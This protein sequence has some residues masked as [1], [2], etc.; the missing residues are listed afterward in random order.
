MNQQVVIGHQT[1]KGIN[2]DAVAVMALQSE[3][4]Y[5]LSV[6][7][8]GGGVNVE[9]DGVA[10]LAYAFNGLL[11]DGEFGVISN[12]ATS[13]FDSFT[14][15]TDDVAYTPE[16]NLIAAA[17][18]AVFPLSSQLESSQL[19][20][21]QL[22]LDEDVIDAIFDGHQ[23]LQMPGNAMQVARTSAMKR[24]RHEALV[25]AALRFDI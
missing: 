12:D 4:S 15:K 20:S 25:D 11:N 13:A 23:K 18:L 19:E 2:L 21:S 24:L 7:M 5:N 22:L 1:S 3:T 9:V 17:A 6:V 8:Q 10:V 16:T 14:I